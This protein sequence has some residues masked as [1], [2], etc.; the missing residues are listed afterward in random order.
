MRT[1]TKKTLQLPFIGVLSLLATQ[2]LA[3]D[4]SGY[5]LFNPVPADQMRELATDRPDRTESAYSVDPGHFQFEADLIN[6]SA[7]G[8]AS[9]TL[10][11]GINA[12]AGLTDSIDVQL[13]LE[14]FV[15]TAVGEVSESG[16]GDTT[17]RLKWNLF[18]N[19][20]GSSALA[21]MPYISLPTRGENIGSSNTTVGLAI[22]FAYSLPGDVSGGI[23]LEPTY[24]LFDGGNFNDHFTFGT[25]ATFSR[26]LWGDFGG[27][28]EFYNELSSGPWVATFD[29]GITWGMTPNLQ[30]DIGANIGA[31]EASDDLNVFAGVSFR[32]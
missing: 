20:E 18:G 11:G 5:N 12:K 9:E 21:L 25:M 3:S 19:D 16:I 32:L 22:P 27:Y 30:W 15:T 28:V 31:S 1:L 14:P 7:S 24:S 29:L 4:K 26:D 17:L 10:L 8:E 2:A 13:V 6:R 23:M